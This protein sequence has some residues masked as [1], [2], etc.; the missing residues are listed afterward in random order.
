MF[1]VVGVGFTRSVIV[2]SSCSVSYIEKFFVRKLITYQYFSL[3]P[4]VESG[5]DAPN[6]PSGNN[7]DQCVS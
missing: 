5:Q 1:P 3:Y 4:F 6:T 2:T 7:Y